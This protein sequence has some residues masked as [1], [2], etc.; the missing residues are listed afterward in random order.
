MLS[1]TICQ[2]PACSQARFTAAWLIWSSNL[3]STISWRKSLAACHFWAFAHEDK[4][5]VHEKPASMGK[6]V[7]NVVVWFLRHCETQTTKRE[8]GVFDCDI[9]MGHLDPMNTVEL[10][11]LSFLKTFSTYLWWFLLAAREPHRSKVYL[12]QSWSQEGLFATNV[13]LVAT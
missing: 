10:S 7:G 12:A 9:M 5:W 6:S 2:R 3:F 13:L 8:M 4:T 1:R 11:K